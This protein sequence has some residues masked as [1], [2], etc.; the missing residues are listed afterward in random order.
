MHIPTFVLEGIKLPRVILLIQP[1]MGSDVQ[2]AVSLMEISYEMGAL[3]FDLPS[4]NHLEA[5]RELKNLVE[6]KGLIGLSHVEAGEGVS[7]L[8]KPL[9]HFEPKI[10]ST[11]KKNHFPP[12][13]ITKL[14]KEGVWN[15]RFFFPTSSS[16]E[17]FT[18]KEV[19]RIR[20][21]A[22]RFEKALSNFRQS[23]T[24]FLVIGRKYG[25]WLSALGRIDL[26]QSMVARARERGFRPIFSSYWTTFVLPK[27][28]TIDVA[29]YAV[30]INKRWSLFDP[31]QAFQLIKK[32]DR[33]VIA[34]N[35]FADGELMQDSEG[36]FS[37]LFE[38]LR[39]HGVIVEVTSKGE[40]TKVLDA[41]EGFPS[42]IHRQKT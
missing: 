31:E 21:D 42:I 14:K 16:T 27:T 40:I 7:L 19:D 25:D 22:G 33:P 4:K 37:F 29:A 8:G 10:A 23:E 32:F 26:L 11:I 34:L 2:A 9:H 38:E 6:D 17:V 5:F 41:I 30:P 13:L 3:C 1:S 18:Q 20:F 15:S 12:H 35:P 28:K 36:A 24:P 39:I